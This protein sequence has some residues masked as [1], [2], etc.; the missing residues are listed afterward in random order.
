MRNDLLRCAAV[1]DT[2]EFWRFDNF[3]YRV[4]RAAERRNLRSTLICTCSSR[5]KIYVARGSSYF[6]KVIG[7]VTA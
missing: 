4:Q 5:K 1:V 7:D 2:G 6:F 3:Q